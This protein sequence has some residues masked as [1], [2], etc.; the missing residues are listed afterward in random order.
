M[1]PASYWVPTWVKR[2]SA[3]L[4]HAPFG[5]WIVDALRPKTI[6]ELGTYSGYS[7]AVFCQA[8]QALRLNCRC[9]GVNTWRGDQQA[10]FNDEEIF[11]AISVHNDSYY[12]S[13]SQLIRSD[14][15]QALEQFDN[16]CIDLLHIDGS[17][18]YEVLRSQ[19]ISW[20]SRLS[21][22]SIVL[23]HD[24]NVHERGF[25]VARLWQDL[26]R[27]HK[28]FEFLHGQGLGVLG[29]GEN[30]PPTLQ[31]L[32][33]YS[34][35]SEATSQLRLAYSRLGA[36]IA[37]RIGREEIQK[38]LDESQAGIANLEIELGRQ[39]ATHRSQLD[40]SHARIANLEIELG[41]QAAKLSYLSAAASLRELREKELRAEIS[42]RDQ[43][44]KNLLASMS[45]RITA[46]LRKVRT[47][48]RGWNINGSN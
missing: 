43:T 27:D 48:F 9:Y 8:V 46:P 45:W 35:D 1:S 16:G 33:H 39:A 32:F 34:S 17:H 18:Q 2:E 30:L 38:Q 13:F 7:Y 10:G 22:S 41:R 19:Y 31:N 47:M 3:W 29:V 20:L 25:G 42:T 36:S 37:D 26:S 44:I 14:F 4:E 15:S 5:F 40:E 6:V 21:S 23:F 11:R 12:A 24:T 28:H